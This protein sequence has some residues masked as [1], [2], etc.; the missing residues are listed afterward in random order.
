LVALSLKSTDPIAV[1]VG[2]IS[3]LWD[4]EVEVSP[5]RPSTGEMLI[6]KYD[7][8]GGEFYSEFVVYPLFRFTRDRTVAVRSSVVS[9]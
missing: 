2:T 7:E 1:Q 9:V 3:E 4:V 5:S 8:N 6:A